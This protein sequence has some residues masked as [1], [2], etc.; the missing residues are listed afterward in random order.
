[1]TLTSKLL[2]PVEDVCEGPVDV[3]GGADPGRAP[4][5]DG[6]G[7]DDADH[8]HHVGHTVQQHHHVHQSPVSFLL[9]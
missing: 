5:L 4:D 7:G 1:M 8:H 6:V 3:D 2:S 9:G